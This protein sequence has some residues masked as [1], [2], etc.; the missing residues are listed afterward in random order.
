MSLIENTLANFFLQY[1]DRTVV[2][3]YSGGVD[4]QV[5]LHALARLKQNNQLDNPLTV[6]HINH[7]LSK[8]AALW[9]QSAQLQCQQLGLPLT[10]C[11]VLIDTSTSQSL[12][13]LARDARY[14][15][16]Q[17][18]APKNALIITGHHSDDQSETF[19]LALKRGAG[20][21][22]LAAM[23]R[24]S[25]LSEHSLVRPLLDVT[26]ED[27]VTYAK[28]NHLDWV[29]D[30]SNS[31]IRFDRNF[32]R[33]QIMPL[34]TK[35]WPAMLSTVQRSSEHCRE[36]QL[37]LTELAEQDLALAELKPELKPESNSKSLSVT[38]LVRLSQ[39]RFN[40]LLRHF[41]QQQGCLMPSAEQLRQVYL[42]ISAPMD[43]TPAV[44]IGKVWLRR[45]QQR[46]YLTN[47]FEDIRQWKTELC[48]DV[49]ASAINQSALT[50]IT[51]P[52]NLGILTFSYAD[53]A[54]LPS[55]N[56]NT[57]KLLKLLPPQKSQK[58]SVSFSHQNP[59]CLPDYRQHSRPLKKV[60]QELALA[61]WLRQRIPF[62]YYDD[63]LVAAA[64][65]FVCKEYLPQN[66]NTS[67]CLSVHWQVGHHSP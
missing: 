48:F 63:I 32:I 14:K 24:I 46:L 4:S 64:G 42:Q 3:A 22:G 61:P 54:V 9:Q 53:A 38:Q 41:L 18:A 56:S 7:G 2:I 26:R 55:E 35:R 1:P 65:Y 47:D 44:K 50:S 17:A 34:L 19:L 33:H 36:G 62:I 59:R 15:A 67:P 60:L 27:I 25:S 29:E 40:N 20:L 5:L 11:E 12:E 57:E 49:K 23:A 39:P 10:V 66:S 28:E 37:L 8:N 6:C 16:L 30:E 52:D 31:D 43:K 21:K 51:L 58:I 13:A 45:Y